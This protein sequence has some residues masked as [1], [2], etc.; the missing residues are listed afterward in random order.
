MKMSSKGFL[1]SDI[2]RI[3]P[4]DKWRKDEHYAVFPEELLQN[5]ILA[6]CPI[7]GIVLDIFSGTGSAVSAALKLGRK[8]IGID[9][10]EKYTAIAKE[11]VCNTAYTLP[12]L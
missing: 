6:T 7:N 8:G 9:L 10:S 4:E 2:W 12:L 11:R 3:T 5:P 1:P